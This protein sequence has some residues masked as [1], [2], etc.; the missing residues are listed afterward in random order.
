MKLLQRQQKYFLDQIVHIAGRHA[1]QQNAMNHPRVAIVEPPKGQAIAGPRGAH[2]RVGGASFGSALG[3][4]GLT[5]HA[6][7]AK[8]KNVFHV[9]SP[10]NDRSIQSPR[11]SCNSSVN[12]D[13]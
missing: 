6:R 3:S 4:H 1:A 7:G 2:E 11:R 10:M 9:A 5:F 8:V 12:K 13:S